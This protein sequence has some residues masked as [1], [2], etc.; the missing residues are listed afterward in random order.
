MEKKFENPE[1]INR[2]FK[3]ILEVN[4]LEDLLKN[5]ELNE[6]AISA[7][8]ETYKD[9]KEK[10]K[11]PSDSLNNWLKEILERYGLTEEEIDRI[12]NE[13]EKKEKKTYINPGFKKHSGG[14]RRKINFIK[15]NQERGK[16]NK[17]DKKNEEENNK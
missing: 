10:D 13:S 12:L 2:K 6:I 14:L 16:E 11:I 8:L 5:T 4:E 1:E 3:E 9:A 17:E 15:E 7:I